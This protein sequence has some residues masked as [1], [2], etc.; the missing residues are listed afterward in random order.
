LEDGWRRGVRAAAQTVRPPDSAAGRQCGRLSN[1]LVLSCQRG[2][3]WKLIRVAAC[4][5]EVSGG[6]ILAHSLER[7][8]E[9]PD[10]QRKR[11]IQS[12]A[13]CVVVLIEELV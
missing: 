12:C 9:A 7:L 10:S 8:P 11:K 2:W 4:V 6:L 5:R 1:R 3:R 13:R